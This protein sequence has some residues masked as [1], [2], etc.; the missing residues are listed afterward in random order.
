MCKEKNNEIFLITTVLHL[1]STSRGSEHNF[2]QNEIGLRHRGISFSPKGRQV[3][4]NN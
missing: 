2:N 1:L 3:N 4:E